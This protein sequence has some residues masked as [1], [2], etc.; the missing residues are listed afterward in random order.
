MSHVDRRPP[1][2]LC[3][4]ALAAVLGPPAGSQ[5]PPPPA[6]PAPA[7]ARPS[8]FQEVIDVNVV[9]LTVRVTDKQGN[10]AKGLTREDFAITEDGKPV[11]VANFYEVVSNAEYGEVKRDRQSPPPAIEAPEVVPETAGPRP[12][13]HVAVL[14]DNANI[15]PR[16]R[17]L[18][19]RGLRDFLHDRTGPGD[20]IMVTAFHTQFDVVQPFTESNADVVMAID[21]LEKAPTDGPEILAER[22][23]VIRDIQAANLV[24]FTQN[25]DAVGNT[26]VRMRVE[27]EAR[28]ILRR[29]ETHAAETRQRNLNTIGVLRYIMGSMAGL[30][31]PKAILYLSDGIE[32]RPAETLFWAHY[33]RFEEVSEAYDFDVRLDP[34]Q[35]LIHDYDLTEQFDKLASDAQIAGVTFFAIDASG[36]TD[37]LGGSAEFS[38]RDVGSAGASNYAPVWNQQLDIMGEQNRHDSLQLLA[39]AT[40]GEVLL[41][42]RDYGSF[43]NDLRRSL[44][45]YYSLGFEAPHDREGRRHKVEVKVRRPDLRLSYQ[46]AYVDKPWEAR[47]SEQTVTTLILGAP[48]GD[49]TVQAIPGKPTPQDKK[50]I[51][52]IQILVPVGALGLVPDG[53][54]Q[55][56]NI[57]LSIVTKDAKGNT[58]P[59]QAMEMRLRLSAEQ[60]KTAANGEANIR[61]LLD[62]EPQEVGIGVRDR[63]SGHTATTKISIDPRN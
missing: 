13:R 34:P 57:S 19:F 61:L 21:K 14:V 26:S 47:L 48:T 55:I 46:R 35:A 5:P 16:N 17:Q 25:T 2:L 28:Q 54:D 56:A 38:L 36:Q 51:V 10:P 7:E 49:M 20:R 29:I 52:P 45:N 22:R 6:A 12:V 37:T 30:P 40:G 58:K 23:L 31:E 9:N 39:T 63:T 3:V 18:V 33:N 8:S 44:D 24:P 50:F 53:N 60:L 4:I 42:T 59:A 11:P 15:H 43:F 41:N 1:A 62:P 32:M 27:S